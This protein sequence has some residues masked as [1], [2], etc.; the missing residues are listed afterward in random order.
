MR[1][2]I[3]GAPGAGKG[4]QAAILAQRLGIPAIS[5]GNILRN[6][7]KKG[8]PLGLSAKSYMDAGGLVPDDVVVGV[9]KDRLDHDDCVG[10]YILDGIPRTVVQAELMENIGIAVDVAIAITADDRIVEERLSGRRVC[11]ECGATYHLEVSPT[12]VEGKCD[13]C[14]AT[15]TLRPDDEPETVRRRLRLYH[16]ET[17]QLFG[18]YEK[19]GRLKQV[20]G[21]HS[22]EEATAAI[23]SALG[24]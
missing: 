18:F 2:V 23:F 7:I 1:L 16:E 9:I 4:T 21:S 6:A 15:L 14:G 12:R 17:E 19:S 24:L 22:I 5:M 11:D 3:L 10:G 20:D 13:K 8:M